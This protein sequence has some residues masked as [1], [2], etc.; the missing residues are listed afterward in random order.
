MGG[1]RYNGDGPHGSAVGPVAVM[2]AQ[3]IEPWSE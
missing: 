2:E 3:G 1:E